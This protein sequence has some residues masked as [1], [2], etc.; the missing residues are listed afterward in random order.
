MFK[1]ISSRNMHLFIILGSIILRFIW[2]YYMKTYP[3]TDFMWYHIK[4]VELSRGMGF[5][6][7]VY[8]YYTGKIGY[9]TA[10][11]P[12]GYPLTLAC[13]Y[14]I[15]GTSFWVGK[16]FNVILST[17]SMLYLYKTAK[18]F[19]SGAVSNLALAIFA[20]SPLSIC[21]TSILGSETLFQTL[22]MLIMYSLFSKKN[23]LTLGILVGYLSLVRPIGIFFSGVLILFLLFDRSRNTL[24]F[25]GVFSLVFLLV[26]SGWFIRNYIQFGK[27]IYS[28]NGGYVIYVNNN[29]YATGSWSDPFSYPNSPFRQYLF[30]DHFD[31]IAINNVGKKLAKEWICKNPKQFLAL[32]SKRIFNSYWNKLD[33]IMWAFPIGLNTWDSRYVSAIKLETF[34]YRPFYVLTFVYIIYAIVN[35]IRYKKANIHTFILFVFLYFSA[36]MFILEGNSRYVF[37]LHPIYSIGISFIILNAISRLKAQRRPTGLAPK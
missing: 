10:F 2:I 36:M 4:G 12:I 34:L 20:F 9:P 6:N 26:I 19:F 35:F 28:T 14:S 27:F 33:D 31:E 1:K 25:T 18:L 22:L 23:A 21:Y 16:I 7:G 29:P 13:L 32:A 5:L 37:P 30:D 3:E 15:F 8:P 17:I 11:R 24:K